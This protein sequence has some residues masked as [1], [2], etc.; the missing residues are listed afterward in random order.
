MLQ[1]QNLNILRLL[2]KVVEYNEP[3]ISLFG[4]LML[5]II[6][7]LNPLAIVAIEAEGGLLALQKLLVNSLFIQY[8]SPSS[9]NTFLPLKK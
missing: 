5:E 6:L 1:I 8:F 2:L 3:R 7:R 9:F 4:L